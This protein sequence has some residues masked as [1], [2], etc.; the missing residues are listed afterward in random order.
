MGVT[1]SI[2]R[3]MNTLNKNSIMIL[4][5]QPAQHDHLRSHPL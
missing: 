5:Q 1:Y 3:N 4:T 2:S